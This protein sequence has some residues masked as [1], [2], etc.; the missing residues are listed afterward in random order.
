M[1]TRWRRRYQLGHCDDCGHTR[2]VT[3]IMFWLN[4]YT[5][6]VCAECIRPYRDRILSRHQP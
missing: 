2:R 4:G 6:Q 1:S 5:M 3:R